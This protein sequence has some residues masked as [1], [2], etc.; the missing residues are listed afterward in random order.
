MSDH[1]EPA[2]YSVIVP[3]GGRFGDLG[4][5]YRDYR[6]AMAALGGRTEF[7]FVFDGP[8]P[9]A[10]THIENLLRQGERITVIELTRSFGE[11]TALMAGFQRANAPVIVTL[12]A[13]DQVEPREIRSWFMRWRK[14]ISPSR[15]AGRGSAARGNR[16]DAMPS[17]AS[18]RRSPD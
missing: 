4:T 15:I 8:N 5:L 12:P 10:A 17:T 13:Y 14:S 9:G 1:F 3:I 18:S 16:S 11:S 2:D 7:I 6:S